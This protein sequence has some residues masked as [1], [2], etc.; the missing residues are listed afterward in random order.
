MPPYQ[1]RR[2]FLQ[3]IVRISGG[4]LLASFSGMPAIATADDPRLEHLSEQEGAN[5]FLLVKTL[6]PH[7]R[8][9][10]GPYWLVVGRLDA[11]SAD[12]AFR[13]LIRSGLKDLDALPAD[14]K[15]QTLKAMEPSAFFQTVRILTLLGLYG[16]P[17]AALK[18]GYEGSSFEQG[19]YLERGFDDLDWLPEPGQ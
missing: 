3:L 4:V 5:L 1:N 2:S 6:F 19:G 9:G 14:K 15:S 12:A 13:G 7:G 10:D 8:L 16:N 17:E 11:M 18:F